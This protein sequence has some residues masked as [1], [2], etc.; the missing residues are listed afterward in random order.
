MGWVMEYRLK[1]VDFMI[2]PT[3]VFSGGVIR[4]QH[5]YNFLLL[6]A[7]LSTVLD[8]IGFYYPLLYYF[9]D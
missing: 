3:E 1:G 8:I 6:H 2:V 5:I 4:L 7:T 9:W